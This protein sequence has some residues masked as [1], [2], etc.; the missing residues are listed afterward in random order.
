MAAPLTIMD[1]ALR[2]RK[3]GF[4]VIPCQKNKKPL[5]KWEAYQTQK[6]SEEE[7]RQWWGKWP[8]ANI[9]I[10]CG[11]V[12]GVDVLDCDSQEA[13]DN[14]NEFYLNDSFRTPIVKTPKGRHLYFKHRSGLS[15]A[16][17]AIKGT[18]IRT[19]GGYV[20]APPSQNGHDST[21]YWYESLSPKDCEF[22]EWPDELFA[23]LQAITH[24]QSRPKVETTSHAPGIDSGILFSEGRRD[25]DLFHIANVLTKGG[26]EEPY[27]R[28]VLETLAKNC[29]PPYPQ[30]EIES[31]IKSA[32]QRRSIKDRNLATELR[33]WVLSTDGEFST[34]DCRRDL[35]ITGREDCKNMSKVFERMANEK[36]IEK[37]GKKNGIFRMIKNECEVMDWINVD[38]QYRDL[39]IPL[40]LGEICGIQPGNILIFAG[41]KDS[42]KTAFLMNCAKENRYNYKVHYFNSEM[43]PAEFKMRAF[44]F[45]EPLSTWKD[46][47][48]YERSEN[49]HD[50]I[51]P[52]EGNLNIIDFLEVV[53]EF[54]K[55]A[56]N[57]QKIHQKLNGA[58]CIIGLQKNQHVDLGRGGAFSIEKA[59]LYI[60]MDYGKAKIVSCKNFKQN[61]IIEGNPRGYVCSYKI[62]H[63]CQ[64][65]RDR[66]GWTNPVD[67]NPK[68]DK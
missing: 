20:I 51:K 39:W 16:V 35:N 36:L 49:F 10:P 8:D 4:S 33:E 2:Y 47:S 64:I 26:C 61:E 54:W 63:G 22:A 14:L 6:P 60:S 38:C 44:L 12:S 45:G 3:C 66:G 65:D 17:R 11:P 9:G 46:V 56:A 55:V 7:I 23:A 37:S 29:T 34:L 62:R 1:W 57:I 53:D 21:Y 31:K 42:G 50:V 18:D 15:N 40:G 27:K 19:H 41:A 13:Y 25:N 52:G 28:V 68:D 5:I 58:L 48:V 32:M 59:R 67:I 30:D 43:G 24:A